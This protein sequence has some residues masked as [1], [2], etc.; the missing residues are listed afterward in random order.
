MN[1][2]ILMQKIE[3]LSGLVAKLEARISSLEESL[4]LSPVPGTDEQNPWPWRIED[5]ELE[6]E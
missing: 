2:E 1:N 4:N 5:A 3:Q 6:V